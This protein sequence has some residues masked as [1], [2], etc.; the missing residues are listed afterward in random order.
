MLRVISCNCP[1]RSQTLSVFVGIN[2]ASN[3]L[4]LPTMA[5]RSQ[6]LSVF[7]RINAPSN[8]L[9]LPTKAQRSLPLVSLR[10]LMLRVTFVKLSEFF[11]QAN[12]R[13]FGASFDKKGVESSNIIRQWPTQLYEISTPDHKAIKSAVG[14]SIVHRSLAY[15]PV[16]LSLFDVFWKKLCCV[17]LHHTKICNVKMWQ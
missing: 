11:I 7:V 1:R 6:T 5:Q 2:V 15:V 12:H 13:F 9:W 3:Q 4:Q 10:E 14:T 17:P 16:S 8:Q